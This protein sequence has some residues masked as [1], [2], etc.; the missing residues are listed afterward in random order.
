MRAFD[1]SS[2]RAAQGDRVD[3]VR[4]NAL[5]LG[6]SFT[7]TCTSAEAM[8]FIEVNCGQFGPGPS[9]VHH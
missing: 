6:R 5:W 1:E 9:V 7:T 2:T 4:R 3:L 8:R